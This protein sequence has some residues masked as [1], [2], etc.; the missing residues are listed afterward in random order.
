MCGTCATADR[1]AS[2]HAARNA[3]DRL[4]FGEAHVRVAKALDLTTA[5]GFD[6]AVAVLAAQ[7]REEARVA[8][9][10]AL[11]AAVRVL[12]VD[13]HATTPTQRKHLVAAAMAV[14]GRATARVP[15]QIRVPFGETAERVVRSTRE[16]ARRD[17]KLSIAV[18]FS[19]LDRRV[20]RH[21]VESQGNFVRDEYGRRIEAFGTQARRVVA[22]GLEQGLGRE[23]IT[24]MLRESAHAAL[25]TRAPFYW[26]IVASSFIVHGRSFAQM[27]SYADAGIRQY[28]IEAVLDEQTT[29]TCRFLHGKVFSVADALRI[30]ERVEAL[31]D[32]N[33]IKQAIPWV[34]ERANA[35]TGESRLVAGNGE[36]RIAVAEF[37]ASAPTRFRPL[38]SD[39]ELADLGIGFPPY[40]GLCRSTTIAVV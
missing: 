39:A 2:L 17:Q 15:A 10:D 31:E 32:P 23:A 5:R 13:W 4:L 16:A 26:E 20:L 40:H 30:F 8:D 11:R 37:H 18:D 34:R 22:R 25:V 21:V 14:A 35:R 29:P 19:A 38:V 28:R 24:D 27:S 6:R 9:V 1:L 36:G 3:A 12:D 33:D 7:L